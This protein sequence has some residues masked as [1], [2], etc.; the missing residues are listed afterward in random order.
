MKRFIIAIAVTLAAGSAVRAQEVEPPVVAISTQ[1]EF[2]PNEITLRR[3]ETVTL[4]VTSTDR[5]H[6]LYS[7]ELAF[8]V[9]IRPNQPHDITLTPLQAGRF[10]VSDSGHGVREMVINVQ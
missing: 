3:G 2:T 5:I 9:D 8:N 7:K 10:V 1:L 4:R 6:H